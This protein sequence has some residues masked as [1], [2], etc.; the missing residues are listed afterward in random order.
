M[1]K[2][3]VITLSI[4]LC[5]S[6]SNNNKNNTEQ[7]TVEPVKE[8]TIV[9]FS[10]TSKISDLGSKKGTDIS[11]NEMI[12]KNISAGSEILFKGIKFTLNNKVNG[13]INFYSLDGKLMCD[14]SMDLSVM[15]MP[16]KGNGGETYLKGSNIEFSAISLIKI[17]SLNF[18]ISNIV[19]N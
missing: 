13:A 11:T 17:D 14:P 4:A 10:I 16:P 19:T 3:L 2:I 6:C 15:S 7:V 1:K 5:Y 9:G 8:N 18:V 12:T